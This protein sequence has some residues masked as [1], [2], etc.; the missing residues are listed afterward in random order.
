ME[1]KMMYRGPSEWNGSV[2]LE[3]GKIYKVADR[4]GSS[5]KV[6]V[7]SEQKRIKY[8]NAN[9]LSSYWTVVEA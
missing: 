3:H 4:S 1:D 8:R 7:G 2:Y 5:M 9:A 6:I